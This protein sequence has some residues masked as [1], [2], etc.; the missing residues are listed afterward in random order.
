MLG[1]LDPYNVLVWLMDALRAREDYDFRHH[2]RIGYDIFS[3]P[4]VP[5]QSPIIDFAPDRKARLRPASL[6]NAYEIN[7]SLLIYHTDNVPIDR[8]SIG[9]S[10]A[11]KITRQ[12]LTTLPMWDNP[13]MI[14]QVTHVTSAYGEVV[15][16]EVG[17][18]YL[19][20]TAEFV[21]ETDSLPYNFV[22]PYSDGRQD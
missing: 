12:A 20:A 13:Y 6:A 8:L 19:T 3:E 10:A 16:P 18:P 11:E 5:I 17:L 15:T 22:D 14:E 7:L 1:V 4:L 2:L 9:L 21:I